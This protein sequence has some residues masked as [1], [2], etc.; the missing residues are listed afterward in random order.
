[1]LLPIRQNLTLKFL[2]GFLALH[3]LN[4]SIDAP[5]RNPEY[6]AE[7]LS[8]NDQ[9]SIVELIVEK[10]FSMDNV[11]IEYDYTDHEDHTKKS[12]TKFEWITYNLLSFS[13]SNV[14][15]VD[16][17]VLSAY[18]ETLLDGHKKQISPPPKS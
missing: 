10:V 15:T 8:I 11:F 1:M 12:N 9:E 5:D 4:V 3:F 17:P 6:V 2:W 16:S 7:N 13:I 18:H 14:E